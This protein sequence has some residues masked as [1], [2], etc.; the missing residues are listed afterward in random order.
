MHAIPLSLTLLFGAGMLVQALLSFRYHWTKEHLL[1]FMG[2]I[3]LGGIIGFFSLLSA[4]AGTNKDA[5]METALFLAFGTFAIAFYYIMKPV[6]LHAI[7]GQLLLVWTIIFWYAIIVHFSALPIAI[8]TL[9]IIPT[10]ITLFFVFR[11]TPPSP[12]W[13]ALL[14]LWF[15]AMLIV[16]FVLSIDV[17]IFLLL[18]AP[19]RT[20]THGHGI[21][22]VLA[23]MWS[24]SMSTFLFFVS[25]VIAIPRWDDETFRSRRH[26][27]RRH[28]GL[29]SDKYHDRQT[30]P[31]Q[32]TV[33]FCVSVALLLMNN[34]MHM[35]SD[36]FLFSLL[37]VASTFLSQRHRE[38]EPKNAE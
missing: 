25:D 23:G 10:G 5:A 28:M 2:A 17:S 34:R 33:A 22:F 20:L 27:V 6:I 37:L 36:G 38:P 8:A 1:Q 26:L 14:Y 29:L 30:H 12:R 31:V 21:E 13:Q 19:A 4:D 11:H 9:L 7:D 16:V 32:L 24:L 15:M 35:V 18:F 3:T